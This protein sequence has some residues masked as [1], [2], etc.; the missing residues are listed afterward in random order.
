LRRTPA[1]FRNQTVD[2]VLIHKSLVIRLRVIALEDGAP[3]QAIRLRNTSSAKEI[4]GTVVNS[5]EVKVT[6]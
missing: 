5:R 6:F 2:A 3:G 1:V 4:R